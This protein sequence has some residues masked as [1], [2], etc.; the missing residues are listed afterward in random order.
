MTRPWGARVLVVL[1]SI[2]ISRPAR[3][4]FKDGGKAVGKPFHPAEEPEFLVLFR[5][6]NIAEEPPRAR[7]AR[8]RAAPGASEHR[9]HSRGNQEREIAEEERPRLRADWHSWPLA[10]RAPAPAPRLSA[11]RRR[12]AL[13]PVAAEPLFRALRCRGLSRT[14]DSGDL[15]GAKGPF[16]RQ[17]VHLGLGPVHPSGCGG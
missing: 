2:R 16:G 3:C 13:R 7:V 17:A 14:I 5:F 10:A 15:M 1:A 9:R 8:H 12:R 11:P 4:S 6:D